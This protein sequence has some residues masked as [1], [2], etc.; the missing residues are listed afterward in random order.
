MSS[1]LVTGP[2]LRKRWLRVFTGADTVCFVMDPSRS[3]SVLARHAGLDEETGQLL[4]HEDGGP[5]L[6]VISS[7]FYAVYQ[8]A[9]RKAD[10]L[11]NLFCTA[12]VRPTSSVPG[13]RARSG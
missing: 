13:T 1:A 3:G 7:D 12:H 5:R 8:S 10:G 11:V 2:G 4:P 9:G 6:V